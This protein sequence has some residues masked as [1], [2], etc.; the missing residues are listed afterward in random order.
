MKKECIIKYAS[1]VPLNIEV[2]KQNEQKNTQKAKYKNEYPKNYL[3]KKGKNQ[4][5]NTKK[6]RIVMATLTH[7]KSCQI[8]HSRHAGT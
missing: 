6:Y 1:F 8:I 5:R 2:D 4:L 7:C 3:K